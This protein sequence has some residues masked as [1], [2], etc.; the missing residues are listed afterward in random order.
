MRGSAQ[1]QSASA[2]EAV[3]A[4]RSSCP[5]RPAWARCSLV[6]T[7]LPLHE[8]FTTVTMHR[9]PSCNCS[10]TRFPPTLL[11]PGPCVPRGRERSRS[12]ERRPFRKS[13]HAAWHGLGS[14]E[15]Q[16]S[17]ISLRPG[18]A[19]CS[20]Q[21]RGRCEPQRVGKHITGSTSTMPS[22]KQYTSV[23]ILCSAP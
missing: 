10:K 11:C 1:C 12:E 15:G 19:G 6:A 5:P 14:A 4:S 7:D 8:A 2:C 20:R 22:V 18:S 16:M 3:Q 13:F 9:W 21:G 17:G 23:L